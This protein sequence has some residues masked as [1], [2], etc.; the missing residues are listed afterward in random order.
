MYAANPGGKG[1]FYVG[2]PDLK[3][4]KSLS[5]ELSVEKDWGDRST[6]HLKLK[7]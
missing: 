5:Y 2:N 4:E 7:I 3:P 1:Q 6:V